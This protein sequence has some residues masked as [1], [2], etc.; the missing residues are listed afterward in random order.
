L[1]SEQRAAADRSARDLAWLVGLVG[2]FLLSRLAWI[3]WRPETASYWE[4]A[5]RW[6]AASELLGTPVQPF[7]DY[8]A[9]HYQGGSLVM[10]LLTLPAFALAG[11]S[12]FSFKLSAL[13][14]S[15]ATLGMLWLLNR[16]FFG[17]PVALLACAA[18]VAGPAVVAYWGLVV[19]GSHGESVLLSLVQI[20][21]FLGHGRHTRHPPLEALTAHIER[22]TP[23]ARSERQQIGPDLVHDTSVG[24]QAIR[25]D[26]GY[27]RLSDEEADLGFR[28]QAGTKPPLH[29]LPGQDVSLQQRPGLGDDNP[30]ATVPQAAQC[31]A[32]AR[33]Q[34]VGDDGL[35]AADVL[36]RSRRGSP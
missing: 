2:L 4:E 12:L 9:D 15:T 17:R 8:Q 34:T 36:C 18:Y 7:L 24:T 32:H 21:L 20:H 23:I 5:Y 31:F 27:V 25:A 35:A 28:D 16:R 22:D 11:E 10:I 33:A 6:V 29:Q 30:C 26:Q 3:A 13:G 19:M 1:T 14:I